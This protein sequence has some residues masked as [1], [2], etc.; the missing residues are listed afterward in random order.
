M[1]VVRESGSCRSK[2]RN[3]HVAGFVG[4]SIS[5]VFNVLAFIGTLDLF[6]WVVF[7]AIFLAVFAGF[8]TFIA[9]ADRRDLP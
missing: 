2:R 8:E 9:W 7:A 4:A 3:L 6:W 1:C 5:Y